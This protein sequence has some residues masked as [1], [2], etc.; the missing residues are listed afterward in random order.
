[1]ASD[2]QTPPASANSV[3]EGSTA[4][5]PGEKSSSRTTVL[6]AFAAVYLFWGS[7]YLGSKFA[8]EAFPPYLLGGIRFV[9]AGALLGGWLMATGRVPWRDFTRGA[10]WLGAGV[11][12]VL[13][14][15]VAN[16]LVSMGVQ[17]VPSGLAA[18]VVGLTSVWIVLFDRLLA[19]AG[20]PPRAIAIGLAMGVTGVAVLGGPS[21]TG[22]GGELDSVGLALVAVSTVAWAA[23]TVLSKRIARPPSILASSAMQMV[24]GG[25]AMFAVSVAFERGAW[26]SAG[27]VGW[28]PWLAIAYLVVFGSL[29]GFTAYVHLLQNVSAAAVATYAYVNPLVALALGAVLA[30]ETVPVRTWF[31]APL[32]LGAVAIMQ[33][34]RPP[35][36]DQLPVD[37]E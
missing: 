1:M 30:G 11:A 24:V 32:I 5:K 14:F 19:R 4:R 21:W 36:P 37:E 9:I 16:G 13:F 17:R 23:A 29:V 22:P 15:A 28:T 12:G 7:T 8:M 33:F 3:D 2:P 35:A 6:M 34:V 27:E 18:L 10:W 31:A 20:A 26:P 25:V